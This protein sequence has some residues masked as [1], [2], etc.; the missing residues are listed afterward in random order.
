M[1]GPL[2]GITVVSLEQAVAAPFATRQLADLGARVIKVERDTGDFARGY[3][4]R[5]DG[6][7]SYFVWLNRGKE[8]I[9]LDLKSEDGITVLR[10]IISRADVFVQNLAP[11]AVSRMGFGPDEALALN[12]RLIHVSI[13]GYGTGGEYEF[14][15]A[16][17]LLI[18]CETG[19]LSITGT[20]ETPVKVGVSI[21]DISAGM[22]AYSGILASLLSRSTTGLGD[23]LEISMLESLAEWL[24]QPLYF[25]MYGGYPPA[26]SGAQHASIAPYGPFDTSDGQIFFGIQNEREWTAF[27]GMVLNNPALAADPRF[28]SNT[29]R[30]TNREALHQEIDAV[31]AGLTMSGATER[32]DHARIATARVRSMQDLAVHPQLA[33]RERWRSVDSPVGPLSL[34]LPPVTSRRITPSMGAI[35]RLGEHTTAILSEFSPSRNEE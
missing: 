24:S 4:D 23:V 27:C 22:Y 7:A 14:K 21:A 16:Y 26:R 5:V 15:K 10:E 34:L 3:D 6:M 20:P 31:F 1:A 30:V 13:S 33:A 8:S 25:A 35:P 17:D 11:G 19:L 18:Q 2:D 12:P 29:L 28:A 32:L 9:V